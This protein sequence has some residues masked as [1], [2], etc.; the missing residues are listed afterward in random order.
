M[1]LSPG[2]LSDDEMS[3]QGS[4][5]SP[6]S[7]ADEKSRPQSRDIPPL[8]TAPVVPTTRPSRETSLPSQASPTSPTSKEKRISRGPPPLPPSSPTAN[9]QQFRAPPPPPPGQ[10]PSWKST[11]Q[12]RNVPLKTSQEGADDSEGE[13]TEYDGD[14]DTDIA[15]S[16]KHKDALKSHARDSSL[17][18]DTL[19]DHRA[20][21]EKASPPGRGPPPLPNV[22]APRDVPPPPPTTQTMKNSRNSGDMPR[23]APPPIPPPK[24]APQ[25][26][27]ENEYDPYRYPAPQHDIPSPGSIKAFSPSIQ[28][29]EAGAEDDDLYDASPRSARAHPPLP[30]QGPP[31]SAPMQPP[32]AQ[33]SLPRQ[34]QDISRSQTATR[35]SMEVPR[36]SGE[37]G[38]MAT[39][40][41]LAPSSQWYAQTPDVP[42]PSLPK[43]NDIFFEIESST[44][45]KRGGKTTISKDIYI[46][47]MD[48]SQTVISASFDASDPTNVIMEQ[49]HE[50]PPPP[51]RQDQL[52][53]ASNQFGSHIASS[54]S[55]KVNTTIGDG[56]PHALILDL[57]HPL[58]T[59]VLRPVG[60]RAYGA[61]V[62]A[63]LANA[64]T[65]QFDEIRPGDIVTFRNAKFAGHKGGLHTKY[66]MEVGKPDHVAVVAD[67][68]GTKKKIRAWEQKDRGKEGG[69]GGVA[70]V[71][72]E[73]YRV[74]DLKSGE[75]RVWRVMGRGWVGWEGGGK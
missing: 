54:I 36:P 61:P 68:D 56:T 6:D 41:D 23:A 19:V 67:W 73:S 33:Q 66:S 15:S 1:P 16:A 74:A 48:Y 52:E 57:L 20:S 44:S 14:Y 31:P 34:S 11:S 55:S 70:K 32:Q 43:R 45:S 10:P 75:V 37:H 9:P 53:A 35:R 29:P 22:S 2:E 5:M 50:R 62:Y 63:N 51:P 21:K 42:P 28:P 12:S 30:A 69:K 18:E 3:F 64:S 13:V 7:I 46:L 59:S 17:D 65:Q 58:S 39:D 38:F 40:V 49:R 24:E 27:D 25:E 26:E 72:E 71:K 8:A 47:Y 4:L 60:T